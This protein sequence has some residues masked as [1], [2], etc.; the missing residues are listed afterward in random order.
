MKKLTI[1]TLLILS[2]F[3]AAFAAPR[4]YYELRTY[5]FK[6]ASQEQRIEAYLGK[7]LLPALHRMEEAGWLGSMW[8]ASE[9]NR[10]AKYYRLTP[11]GRRQLDTE[12]GQWRRVALAITFA[13]QAT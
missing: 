5:R 9:N 12:I 6:D 3:S 2:A 8:G 7:A 10:K 13:L 1:L 11:K 4:E